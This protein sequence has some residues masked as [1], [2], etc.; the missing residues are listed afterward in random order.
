MIAALGSATLLGVEGRPVTVEVHVANGL[1]AFAIVGLPDAACREARDRVRAAFLSS[2]LAWPMRRVT[3]NL[4]PSSMRKAGAGLDLAIAVGLLVATGEIDGP[5]TRDCAFLGELG[6]DGSLRPVPGVLALVD[7]AQAP[8]VVCPA[9]S[10]AEARLVP[11]RRVFG[12][13]SLL[14]VLD[15]LTGRGAWPAPA[16]R[17]PTGATGASPAAPAPDLAGVRGQRVAKRALEVAATG[18]HHVLFVGPPG[19]GK[20]MLARCLPGLLPPLGGEDALEVARVRSAAG[21]PLPPPGE[22]GRPPFRAP[23]HSCSPV[24]LVGGGTTQLRPGE[25]SLASGGVLFLDELGEFPASVL[26]TLRQ[27]L[28]DGAVLV[29]RARASTRLPARVLLVAAANPCPCGEGT[30]PGACRCTPAMRERYARR[31]SAPF[32]DRFDLLVRVDRPSPA[33]LLSS[34]DAEA[35]AAVA[36]RVARARARA[37]ERGVRAN[38]QLSDARLDEVA[39]LSDD[40]RGLLEARLAGGALSARGLARIRRVARTLADL[41]GAGDVLDAEHVAVAL[42]L[43][44]ARDVLLGTRRA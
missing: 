7:A 39:V 33:D 27:P 30:E 1:P 44:S 19:A 5:A 9:A 20:T 24:A 43:R 15:G 35:T 8:A 23:H 3:V 21:L 22:L 42:E 37:A 17:E 36:A 13:R 34:G 4:A 11:G 10:L 31:L 29:S 41:A 40:A 12:A 26:E 38:A 2:G 25:L 16:P 32:L 18:A 6:L 14:E 28:E